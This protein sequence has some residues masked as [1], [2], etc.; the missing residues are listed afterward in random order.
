ME[1][2]LPPWGT[3]VLIPLDLGSISGIVM[4]ISNF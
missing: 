2:G 1:R 4:I 3:T